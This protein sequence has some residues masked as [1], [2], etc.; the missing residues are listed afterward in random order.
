VTVGL[1]NGVVSEITG[2][3]ISSGTGVITDIEREARVPQ[4]GGPF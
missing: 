4:G 2:G 3:N 1:S